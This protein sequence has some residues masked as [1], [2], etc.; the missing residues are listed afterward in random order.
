MPPTHDVLFLIVMLGVENTGSSLAFL[1]LTLFSVLR[2][3]VHT[4][5]AM[6]IEY[7]GTKQK[8]IPFQNI[9]NF[10]NTITYF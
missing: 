4:V 8:I 5:F 7:L 6:N 10:S 2:K 3:K 1:Y 9:E